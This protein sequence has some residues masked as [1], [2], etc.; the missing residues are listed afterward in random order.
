VD[1]GSAPCLESLFSQDRGQTPCF[2]QVS[3]TCILVQYYFT[4]GFLVLLWYNNSV[5]LGLAAFYR[6]DRNVSG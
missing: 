4:V 6:E 5:P 1:I 3:K 2:K